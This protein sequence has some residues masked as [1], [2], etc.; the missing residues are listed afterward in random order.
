MDVHPDT[1]CFD[2][3]SSDFASNMPVLDTLVPQGCE[4]DPNW[5][6]DASIWTTLKDP[7][8]AKATDWPKA[9]NKKHKNEPTIA[10]SKH[11]G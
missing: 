2:N 5:D 6:L 3:P 9:S 11:M 8:D 4:E 10:S 7:E 1:D